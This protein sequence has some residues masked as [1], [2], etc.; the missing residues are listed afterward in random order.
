ML[1]QPAR[2]C[3]ARTRGVYVATWST[4]PSGTR[5]KSLTPLEARTCERRVQRADALLL[6]NEPADRAVDLTHGAHQR[7]MERQSRLCWMKSISI[8]V[9]LCL[10]GNMHQVSAGIELLGAHLKIGGRAESRPIIRIKGAGRASRAVLTASVVAL[11]R[12]RVH[13]N[14]VPVRGPL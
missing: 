9:G 10:P 11:A 7:H 4:R 6:R 13:L 2:A 5:G 8:F 14:W 12:Q 1:Q 3:C